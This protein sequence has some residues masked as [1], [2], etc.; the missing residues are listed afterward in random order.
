M[1]YSQI[2]KGLAM[3]TLL[4]VGVNFNQLD[5]ANSIH[6]KTVTYREATHHDNKDFAVLLQNAIDTDN[7]K[8]KTN[9]KTK[10]CM[11]TLPNDKF[12]SFNALFGDPKV[13]IA[14]RLT[15]TF[16]INGEPEKTVS[17]GEHAGT[18]TIGPEKS[19]PGYTEYRCTVY[20]VFPADASGH[21]PSILIKL[22]DG[23][24]KLIGSPKTLAPDES[25]TIRGSEG[26]FY[27]EFEIITPTGST[28]PKTNKLPLSLYQLRRFVSFSFFP[29]SNLPADFMGSG[30]PAVIMLLGGKSEITLNNKRVDCKQLYDLCYIGVTYN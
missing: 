22:Y 17:I 7:A 10:S 23:W 13:G 15:V 26:T 4:M 18:I 25:L 8:A 30:K 3:A 20:N 24:K 12:K 5:A 2:C 11:Y 14:K 16:S 29:N 27:G 6:I 9:A 1:R 28:T 21:R 19:G